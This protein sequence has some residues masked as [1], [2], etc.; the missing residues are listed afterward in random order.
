V[1]RVQGAFGVPDEAERD[2]LYSS[3]LAEPRVDILVTHGPPLGSSMAAKAAPHSAVRSLGLRPCLH[4]FGH[5]HSAHGVRPTR[6][7]LFVNAAVLD[8]HGAPSRAPIMLDFR[9]SGDGR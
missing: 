9:P 6:R 1:T 2:V 7:T 5:V 8:E 4:V 3:I